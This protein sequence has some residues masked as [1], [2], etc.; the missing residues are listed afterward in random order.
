MLDRTGNTAGNI[1][2][3]SN[4]LTG[5]SYLVAVADPSGVNSCTGSAYS[6]A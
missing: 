2:L 4:R 6:A 3:R 5:L 1:K